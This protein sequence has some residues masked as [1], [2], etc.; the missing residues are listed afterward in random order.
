MTATGG[1]KH[2]FC[3]G[4]FG[5]ADFRRDIL[6]STLQRENIFRADPKDHGF[7]LIPCGIQ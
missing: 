4:Q 2:K 1:V 6:T 3:A 7:A 5:Y